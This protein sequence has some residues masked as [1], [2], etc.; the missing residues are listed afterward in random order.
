FNVEARLQQSDAHVH[1]RL[2]LRSRTGA[3][4]RD[5]L[6]CLVSSLEQRVFENGS[7]RDL[8][9]MVAGIQIRGTR[10]GQRGVEF[11]S[12]RDVTV[13]AEAGSGALP[14]AP[15]IFLNPT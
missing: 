15:V 11:H 13:G 4:E 14:K 8:P 9:R 10:I 6:E 5:G 1:V 2:G 12:D 7:D 3:G